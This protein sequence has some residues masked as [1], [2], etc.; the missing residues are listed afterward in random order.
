MTNAIAAIFAQAHDTST[1]L[2]ET[3]GEVFLAYPSD[4]DDEGNITDLLYSAASW[5]AA[6]G[7]EGE[8]DAD[9]EAAWFDG[10]GKPYRWTPIR[11]AATVDE[12]RD[13]LTRWQATVA[14]HAAA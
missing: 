3:D 1:T 8:I 7:P 14:A 10:W 9:G 12:A 11:R 6:A 2:V 5:E 13:L 4:P